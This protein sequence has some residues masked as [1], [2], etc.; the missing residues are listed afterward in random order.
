[1]SSDLADRLGLGDRGAPSDARPRGPAV[2]RPS[3]S[4]VRERPCRRGQPPLAALPAPAGS[5]AGARAGGRA[6]TSQK[7]ALGGGQPPVVGGRRVLGGK[8]V[9]EGAGPPPTGALVPGPPGG[10]GRF[11]G[12]EPWGPQPGV[13]SGLT[14][15]NVTLTISREGFQKKDVVVGVPAEG[16]RSSR[17]QLEPISPKA[18]DAAP[19]A[20]PV[21]PKAP[22]AVLI[23]HAEPEATVFL[24]GKNV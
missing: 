4:D 2:P 24:D 11:G 10:Q 19:V 7:D 17:V 22:P 14:P 3:P 1:R 20:P 18:E 9:L 16:E 6:R 8:P 12:P 21:E 5:G 15:P 23:V 13:L